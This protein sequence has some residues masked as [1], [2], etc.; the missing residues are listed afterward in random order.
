MTP[1]AFY[2]LKEWMDFRAREGE[3]ITGESWLMRNLWKTTNIPR[4]AVRSLA[5]KPKRWGESGIKR[6]LN[7]AWR[8]QGI[9]GILLE[10][11][12]RHEIKESHG[13]IKFHD[14]MCNKAHL[15]PLFSELLRGHSI[16]LPG[17]YLRPTEDELLE[18]FLKAAPLLTIND[19]VDK[20]IM[21][22]KIAELTEK[23][24]RADWRDE[25]LEQAI[26]TADETKQKLED[27]TKELLE[28]KAREEKLEKMVELY[29]KEKTESA[30]QTD[31][32]I[33]RL[34]FELER[35]KDERRVTAMT[36]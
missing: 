13:F 34:E 3:K 17:H 31:E 30:D 11:Q 16:G 12:T 19:I 1:E 4:G 33:K 8:I 18:Q 20:A 35:V 14:T 24:E 5:S 15:R 23:A 9:R 28:F 21:Q 27:T 36:A 32:R 10:G 2:A 22:K 29:G 7:R 25:E 26:N 6:R